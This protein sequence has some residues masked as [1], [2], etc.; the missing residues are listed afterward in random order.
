M[1][2][3]YIQLHS[4]F[5]EKDSKKPLPEGKLYSFKNIGE[6]LTYN[7]SVPFIIFSASLNKKIRVMYV[8]IESLDSNWLDP[9]TPYDS[10]AILFYEAQDGIWKKATEEV[11]GATSGL[12]FDNMEDPFVSF[13]H[14]EIV[15]G[16]VVM[17]FPKENMR[18]E[19]ISVNAE[20]H[21]D[22][23]KADVIVTTQ[24]YRGK[25]I[26]ELKH[27]STIRDMKDI[28]LGELSDGS[29]LVATRPQGGEAGIGSIGVVRIKSLDELNQETIDKAILIKD[30]ASSDIKLGALAIYSEGNILAVTAYADE[31]KIWHYFATV[32]KIFNPYTFESEGVMHSPMEVIAWRKNWPEGPSKRLQTKDVIFPSG[33]IEKDGSKYLITGLSDA[34]IGEIK[35]PDPFIV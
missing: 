21:F 17:E 3:N 14:G 15:F 32:F 2:K 18:K 33:I 6:K 34:Q 9:T 24:F 7:P 5:K 23:T 20:A 19:K 31:N 8:R 11:V 35:I 10:K 30:L 25:T 27:F 16:G 13:I 1:Q 22:Y 12:I 4:E 26:G 28:R 29:I